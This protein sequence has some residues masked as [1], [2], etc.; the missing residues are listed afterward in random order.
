M[1]LDLK[2]K[3]EN[4]VEFFEIGKM[5]TVF[6]QCFL[7]TVLGSPL[8]QYFFTRVS[9]NFF[10]YFKFSR[11]ISRYI[12]YN[13]WSRGQTFHVPKFS[14]RLFL[15]LFVR[16]LEE[17]VMALTAVLNKSGAKFEGEKKKKKLE[18]HNR[19]FLVRID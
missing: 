9:M 13:G 10:S 17:M 12:I 11:N 8:K 1:L 18:R 16:K 5:R 15:L 7:F 2:F 14:G 19:S 6:D 3:R 4:E